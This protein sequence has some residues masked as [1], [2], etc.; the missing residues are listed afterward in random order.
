MA[1]SSSALQVGGLVSGLD[2]NA[3]IEGLTQIEQTRVDR[4][5]SKLEKI[6]EEKSAFNDLVS[7]ISGLENTAKDL[8]DSDAFDLFTATSN[9]DKIATVTGEDGATP[10]SFDVVVQQLATSQKVASRNF[11]ATNVS[12]GLTGSYEIS[13]SRA[14]IDSDPSKTSNTI[15]IKAT[16]ALSD[17]VKK[18][19][20]AEGTSV[21]ASILTLNDG[22][23]RLV[24]TAAEQG[25]DTFQIK[26]LTGDAFSNNTTGLGVL[27]TQ[28]SI[29]SEFN[30]LKEEGLAADASTKFSDLFTTIGGNKLTTGDTITISGSSADGAVTSTDFTIDTATST[31]DDLLNTIRTAFGANTNVSLNKSGEI[32]LG[33]TGSGTDTMKLSL[34]YTGLNPDSTMSLG[35]SKSQ[36]TFRSIIN[37]G[38][39]SFYMLDGMAVSSQSNADNSTIRGATVH[40]KKADPTQVVKLGLDVDT[41]GIK[42]KIQTLI[43]SYNTV[44]KFIDEQSKVTVSEAGSEDAKDSKTDKVT[45]GVLANNSTVTRIKSQLREI[46]T[47]Q[48]DMLNN[49]TQYTSLSRMG[50]TSDKETGL[51][52]IDDKDLTKALENDIDGVKAFFSYSGF[53]DNPQHE[54]GRFDKKN[55]QSGVYVINAAT[56]QIDGSTATRV[57]DILMSKSG[58]SKGLSLTAAIGSGTGNF[59]F[60]RG[61]GSMLESFISDSKDISN[62]LFKQTN[63]TYDKRIKEYNERIFTMEDKVDKFKLRLTT[64]FAALEQSMQRL[65]SQSAAFSAQIK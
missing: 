8:S 7:R 24:L 59:T 28:Q 64:Q 65:N 18:I 3:I 19:N 37:E 49:K 36:N 62:G 35:D 11:A 54:M 51:L 40:L 57:G 23:N 45:K 14:S 25:T 20:A 47:S 38:S 52:E 43:D 10:G 2:T 55:T 48:I 58:A 13:R 39:R 46:M 61:L 21:K 30:F 1:S 60:V 16:D 34:S 32:V 50:I 15:E 26:E 22:Q 6:E 63:E 33:N 17:I 27:N 12:L 31:I 9:D 44:L 29:R 53:S 41:D 56:D 4:E 42:K 5:Q